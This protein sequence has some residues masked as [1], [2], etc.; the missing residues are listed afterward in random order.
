MQYIIYTYTNNP[1]LWGKLNIISSFTLSLNAKYPINAVI[2]YKKRFTRS[3]FNSTFLKS[4]GYFIE[5]LIKIYKFYIFLLP[6]IKKK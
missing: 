2:I 1:L 3:V 6:K 4:K 5:C